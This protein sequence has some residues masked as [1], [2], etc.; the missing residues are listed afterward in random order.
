MCQVCVQQVRGEATLWRCPLATETVDSVFLLVTP[1]CPRRVPA[2]PG[3]GSLLGTLAAGDAV[4]GRAARL[5][6]RQNGRRR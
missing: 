4:K 5:G 6:A 1:V 2:V 3:P